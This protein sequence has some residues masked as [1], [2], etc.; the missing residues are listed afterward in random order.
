MESNYDLAWVERMQNFC[1]SNLNTFTICLKKSICHRLKITE[2]EANG[3][4][5]ENGQ[6]W[7]DVYQNGKQDFV[8]SDF[9]NNV[10]DNYYFSGQN[11]HHDPFDSN[12]GKKNK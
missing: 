9:V 8:S 6:G 5:C 1:S 11:L 3:V 7:C 2:A 12:N 10:L 4:C